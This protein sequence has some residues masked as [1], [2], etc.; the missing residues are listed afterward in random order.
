MTENSNQVGQRGETSHASQEE[1]RISEIRY[2]RLFETARDGI[3]IMDANTR[4][5]T[6]VNPF[7]V[8]LLGYPREEFLGKELFEIGLLRDAA[9][10]ALAFTELQDSGYIRYED[11]PLETKWGKRREV[12]FVSN[13]YTENGHQVI[14]CNIRD[15]TERKQTEKDLRESA[16]RRLFVAESMPQ[17]I[18]TALADGQVDYF[19]TQ[20]AEFTGETFWQMKQGGWMRFVHPDDAEENARLWQQSL[21]TGQPFLFEHRFRRADGVYRWHLSHAR[22]MRDEKG[23]VQMW[24]SSNTDIEDQKAAQ[25]ELSRLMMLEQTAR[26]A[27]DVANRTKDDFLATVSHELRTPITVVLGWSAL[28]RGERLDPATV[29]AGLDAIDRNVQA[30][31]QLIEDILDVSRIG[32]GKLRLDVKPVR[33]ASL[34]ELAMD[35]GSLAAQAK[36][37]ALV[38]KLD[39]DV[40][41]VAG[42]PDRLQQV[43]ANLLTN[44]IKFTGRGGKIEVGLS[45]EHSHAHITV[46]DNGRGITEEFLPFIFDSFRQADSSSTRKYNGLGLGLSIVR[47]IVEMHGGTVTARSPGL[48]QGTT[49]LVSIPLMQALSPAKD[50]S[51]TGTDL[52]G[53]PA[54]KPLPF[55]HEARIL[56]VDDEEDLRNMLS[57]ILVQCGAE[58]RS[59]GSAAGALKIMEDWR[60]DLLLS[61]IAM[62]DKDGLWLISE[63][64]ALE[65]AQGAGRRYLPAVAL[66]A[67]VKVET[68]IQVLKA[69]FDMFLPKPVIPAELLAVIGGLL[70]SIQSAHR[71]EN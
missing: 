26:A 65:A 37:I 38:A 21:D 17:K 42:D 49:I 54:V 47:N 1:L 28:L 61:D 71:P 59:S 4:K 55:L 62:P 27:A 29:S 12:E 58:V 11:L 51:M 32:T 66:T 48:D 53:K 2:R 23:Q 67:Y 70:P 8:E 60:P 15:I 14:Q 46:S 25:Q 43:L 19:N 35:S 44:A 10:S 45:Q 50:L 5:I 57:A 24:I 22:A 69:G 56:V 68:R 6:D 3:L 39:P 36:D 33:L 7:M 34:I 31:L 13:V 52:D 63:I 18:F 30:Q 9:A 40:G 16:D 41:L 20:W 64:R